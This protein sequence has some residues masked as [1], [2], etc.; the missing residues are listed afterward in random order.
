MVREHYWRP[1]GPAFESCWRH[2]A[3]EQW[4][5]SVYPTVT[6]RGSKRSPRHVTWACGACYTCYTCPASMSRHVAGRRD[7]GSE[8]MAYVRPPYV[9]N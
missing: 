5:F 8:S 2:F 3:S 1:R 4:Q 7:T 9:L 6:A